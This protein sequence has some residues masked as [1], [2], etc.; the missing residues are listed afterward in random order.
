MKH[1]ARP[2]LPA[3]TAKVRLGGN[4]TGGKARGLANIRSQG[5]S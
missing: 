1:V 3:K 5:G 4:K 2:P